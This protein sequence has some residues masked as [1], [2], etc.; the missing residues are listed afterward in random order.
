MEPHFKLIARNFRTLEALE[1]SPQV[2][3]NLLVG[4]NG[5]GKTT[6]LSALKF[7]RVLFKRGHE[8]AFNAIR[9]VHLGRRGAAD[10][11]PVHLEL[12]HGDIHWTLDFPVDA[13]GLRSHYGESLRHADEVILRSLMFQEMWTLGASRRKHADDRCCARV[14]W[15]QAEEPPEWMR[16]LVDLVLNLRVHGVYNLDLL[17]QPAQGDERTFTLHPTGRNLWQ[18]LS[19]WKGSPRRHGDQFAWVLQAMR[20]AFPDLIGE[21]EFEGTPP[22]G[23]IFPPGTSDPDGGLPA[24][25]AADGLL[26]GLL[27]LTAIAG[28]P[29]G[30]ILAFDEM[31]NQ[32]HPFAIRSILRSMRARAEE[33]GLVVLLTTHSPTV[34][35][36]F[37]GHEDRFYVMEPGRSPLPIALS[38]LHDPVWLTSFSLGLRYDRGD[39]AAPTR[40]QE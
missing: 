1:W 7:L 26:T 31:E 21:L 6:V 22:H 10:N 24:S 8:S 3:V 13:R 16:P 12:H 28:A 35:D 9:G 2:G 19:L 39:V 14:F 25:L 15:D 20:D 29:P 34:M 18:L 37:E 30:S 32:L 36:A 17:R 23:I 38:E 4:P 27:H 40:P 11:E 5:S 33:R